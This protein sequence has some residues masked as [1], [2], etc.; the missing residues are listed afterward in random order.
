[1]RL[2]PGVVLLGALVSPSI[3]DP[4]LQTDDDFDN[5]M[6][7]TIRVLQKISQDEQKLAWGGSYDFETI[8]S[9]YSNHDHMQKGYL[10]RALAEHFLLAP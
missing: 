4:L 10:A 7:E 1:M 9:R 5:S 6:L 3:G 2:V 8:L